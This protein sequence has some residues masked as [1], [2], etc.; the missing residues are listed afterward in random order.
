M[1][2][3]QS[4]ARLYG[5]SEIDPETPAMLIAGHVYLARRIAWH[6]HGKV[7]SQIEVEDLIQIGMVALVEAANA[8]QQGGM[9]AAYAA[10]R[11][12][13]AILDELRRRAAMSRGALRRR[14]SLINT[15][16][17][18]RAELGR[19]PSDAEAAERLGLDTAEFAALLDEIEG[20]KYTSIDE[21]YSDHSM[22]FAADED[23]AFDTA[24]KAQLAAR[25]AEAIK[26]LPER[27]AIVLQL[28]F[29]EEMNLVEIGEILGV[30]AARVSQLKSTA[31][32]KVR[33]QLSPED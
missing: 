3:L 18:L 2:R 15:R 5:A 17:E 19:E 29:V 14:R 10:M 26:L 21:V 32:A 27:E 7:H 33:L 8:H 22:W 30:T 16:A 13:G 23:D 31:L 12:K 6:L 20:V 25:L 9:F 24:A 4:A 11:I 1:L 28:Y